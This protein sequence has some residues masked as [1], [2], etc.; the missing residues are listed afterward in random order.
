VD[1]VVPELG[2]LDIGA[3]GGT[4]H[5]RIFTSPGP[6][7]GSGDV[8]DQ[9]GQVIDVLVCVDPGNEHDPVTGRPRSP[10]TPQDRSPKRATSGV[11]SVTG[12]G[13]R[14]RYAAIY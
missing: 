4:L 6:G 13:A 8:L 2:D 12:S 14:A 3:A 1:V 5:T 10:E 11:H 9:D 7:V